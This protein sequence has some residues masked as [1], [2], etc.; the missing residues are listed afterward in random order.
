M[1]SR[2]SSTTS[3]WRSSSTRTFSTCQWPDEPALG[4]P[5]RRVCR[6]ERPV[7]GDRRGIVLTCPGIRTHPNHGGPPR[8]GGGYAALLRVPHIGSPGPTWTAG[9]FTQG[10]APVGLVLLVHRDTG[11][12]ISAGAVERGALGGSRS[13]ASNPGTADRPARHPDGDA[14]LRAGPRSRARWGGTGGVGWWCGLGDGA[15]QRRRRAGAPS[16]LGCDARGA[17]TARPG[18]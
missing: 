6:S 9:G 17:G 8:A 11:S 1:R 3:A 14:R 4:D 18:E 10:A 13:R 16:G 7:L 5:H 2:C 12:L 15:V